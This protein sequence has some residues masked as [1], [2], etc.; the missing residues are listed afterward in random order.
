M[1]K[2]PQPARPTTKVIGSYITADRTYDVVIGKQSHDQAWHRAMN[3][4]EEQ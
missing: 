1:S 4:K 3:H 2:K